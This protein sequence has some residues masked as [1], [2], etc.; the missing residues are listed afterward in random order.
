MF[1]LPF[2]VLSFH[3]PLDV[4][5][6]SVNTLVLSLN[7]H[8]LILINV[9]AF[10][11][12][13]SLHASSTTSTNPASQAHIRKMVS[14]SS[15]W[16]SSWSSPFPPPH[17]L[18]GS[19]TLFSAWNWF[20]IENTFS[21]HLYLL[22]PSS[23][24]DWQSLIPSRISFGSRLTFPSCFLGAICYLNLF[25]TLQLIKLAATIRSFIDQVLCLMILSCLIDVS[26]ALLLL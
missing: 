24:E 20:W 4:L 25:V 13:F 23:F 19:A 18:Q 11:L 14:F 3:S 8:S 9:F 15:L 7:L 16:S 5:V 10:F 17:K 21:C 6:F 1:Q 2:C 22:S 26:Q 12:F